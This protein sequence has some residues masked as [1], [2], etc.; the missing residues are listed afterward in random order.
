MGYE[1]DFLGVGQ[2]G[3]SGDAILM[4]FGDLTGAVPT[5]RTALLDGGF[6]ENAEDIVQHME[7]Y[8]GTRHLDLVISS[9]PDADHI[10]GLRRLMEKVEAGEVSVG[11]LWMHRPSRWRTLITRSLTNVAG[12]EYAKAVIRTLNAGEELEESAERCGIPIAEPFRGVSFADTLVVIGPTEEFYQSLFEEEAE[13]AAEE[14]RMM[15]WLGTARDFLAKVAE[16]WDFETLS[17]DGVTSPINNS[18]TIVVLRDET[19][20][21]LFTAD[22]GMPALNEAVHVL[23]TAGILESQLRLVQVPHHGSRRNMGPAVLNRLL[24]SRRIRD[25]PSAHAVVSCARKGAPKH[26][27]KKVTNAFRRRGRKVSSTCGSAIRFKKD[28]PDR[29]GWTP[30]TPLPFYTE[31]DE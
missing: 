21:V 7:T 19:D 2:E 17:D 30:V 25:E 9:H 13:A 3:Q 4:R 20:Y 1:I 27:A 18:S 8:Y 24:G 15:K 23:E 29:P 10:N 11:E 5:Y 22:A 31:V 6:A 26:P 14:S 12:R 16:S 28:A